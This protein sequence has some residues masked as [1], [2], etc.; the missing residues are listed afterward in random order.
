[1]IVITSTKKV[2]LS[3]MFVCLLAVLSCYVRGKPYGYV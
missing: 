2:M 1:M 3:L